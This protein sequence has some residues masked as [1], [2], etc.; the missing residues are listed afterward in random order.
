MV[1]L[2]RAILTAAIVIATVA[3]AVGGAYPVWG[4]MVLGEPVAR[5]EACEEAAIDLATA[6]AVDVTPEAELAALTSD[7]PNK[8]DQATLDRLYRELSPLPGFVDIH[9]V[10]QG[11]SRFVALFDDGSPVELPSLDAPY[12]VSV[13]RVAPAPESSLVPP[14][15]AEDTPPLIPVACPGVRPGVAL[16]TPVGGCTL[17]W[18]VRSGAGKIFAVS[19]GHCFNA[20]GQRASNYGTVRFFINGGVGQDF[21]AI[22]IDLDDLAATNPSM[23]HWGG[24]TGLAPDDATDL[25][26]RQYGFGIGFGASPLTRPRSGVLFSVGEESFS[27][28]GPQVA[29]DSGSPVRVDSGG[30]LG[31]HTHGIGVIISL[32]GLKFGTRM[33]HGLDLAGAALG[34]NFQLLTAPIA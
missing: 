33:S 15:T 12:P 8:I 18:I 31:V 4:T 24:P 23:C 27:Y 2:N 16:N 19:A 6:P 30:A 28:I 20:V 29:G 10:L 3:L 26:V 13:E 11:P 21:S 22:E 32:P 14:P 17:A 7:T 25:L 9:F 1:Q 5:E 34:T